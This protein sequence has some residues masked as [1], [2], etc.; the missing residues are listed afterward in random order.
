M[1]EHAKPIYYCSACFVPYSLDKKVE[2]LETLQAKGMLEPVQFAKSAVPTIPT[3]KEDKSIQMYRDYKG[4]SNQAAKLDNYPI[5][6]TEDLFATL[7]AISLVNW[8]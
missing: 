3:I 8:K 4:I 1:A 2:E 5:P 7:V 6:E